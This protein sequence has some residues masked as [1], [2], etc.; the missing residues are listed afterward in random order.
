MPGRCVWCNARQIIWITHNEL[1]CSFLCMHDKI[2]TRLHLWCTSPI[3]CITQ[4]LQT[5]GMC[6]CVDEFMI[7]RR[8][9][10]WM[11]WNQN[12][13]NRIHSNV[14]NLVIWWDNLDFHHEIYNKTKH[15]CE[16]N[17]RRLR[18][19][20]CMA[21]NEISKTIAQNNK[22]HT[23]EPSNKRRKKCVCEQWTCEQKTSPTILDEKNKR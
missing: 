14:H 3:L 22:K 6:S 17:G 11:H 12:E 16:W 20:N 1:I 10:K 5:V 2:R 23:H 13:K 18:Q 8:K 15:K 19:L 21:K 4:F 7:E 9:K